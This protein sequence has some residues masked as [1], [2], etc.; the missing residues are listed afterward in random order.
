MVWGGVLDVPSD[1]FI[2]RHM[3]FHGTYEPLETL[4]VKALAARGS[5]WLDAGANIGVYSVLIGLSVGPTGR[6]YAF[7][8]NPECARLI[9]HNSEL[10]GLT[11]VTVIEAA[12]TDRMCRSTLWVPT[13]AHTDGGRLGRA[14]LLHHRDTIDREIG[15]DILG[16]S[17]DEWLSIYGQ[18]PPEYVKIDIEG[19]ELFAFRG[20]SQYLKTSPPKALLC[21]LNQRPDCVARPKELVDYLAQFG[22][23]PLLLRP[24]GLVRLVE[25]ANLHAIED[26]N[27]LFVHEDSYGLTD[28][29]NDAM[30]SAQSET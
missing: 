24:S 11:N 15:V 30:A 28:R 12:L 8:P 22:Y 7:E 13:D 1:D 27:A 9:R 20:M 3:Y 10:N 16:I 14:S 25:R 19:A 26:M 6:V 2:Y 21:E 4:V 5:V 29:V 18:P 17:F 23:I